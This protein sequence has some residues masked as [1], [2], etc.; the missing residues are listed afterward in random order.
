VGINDLDLCYDLNVVSR[1][2]KA[3]RVRSNGKV[4]RLPKN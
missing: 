1:K 3:N 4:T 2:K